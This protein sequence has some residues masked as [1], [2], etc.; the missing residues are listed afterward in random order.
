MKAFV[1]NLPLSVER[2]EYM[3]RVLSPYKDVLSVEFVSAV[4]GRS[5]DKDE[6]SQFFNQEVAYGRYGRTLKNGEIGCTLSHIMCSK[7]L[8]QSED[9]CAL[10][11]E[12]D[13]VLGVDIHNVIESCSLYMAS[14]KPIIILLSGDYW[15]TRLIRTG[16]CTLAKVREAVCSQAY[17]I[18]RSAARILCNS[19]HEHLADDW[20]F[21]KKNGIEVLAVYPHVADQNRADFNTEISDEYLGVN[22]SNLRLWKRIHSY[23]RAIVK[24]CLARVNHFESKSFRM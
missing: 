20:F 13:L 4:D 23:W 1:I 14:E 2:K 5:M 15:W 10:V 19:S 17:F 22:R 3:K 24:H 8:L 16:D 11:F 21:I 9:N 6:I 7:L 18:N 12:D